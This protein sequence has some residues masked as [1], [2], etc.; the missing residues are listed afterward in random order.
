MLTFV[1]SKLTDKLAVLASK[2][3]FFKKVN[4]MKYLVQTYILVR[5]QNLLFMYFTGVSH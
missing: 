5:T 1:N 4:P 3:T 2:T